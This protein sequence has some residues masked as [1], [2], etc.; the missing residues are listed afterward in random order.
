[1]SRAP[2]PGRRVRT[3]TI[4]QMEAVEC[5]AAALAIVLAHHDRFVPLEELRVACGVSRD[6]SKASNVLKAARKYGMVA[7]GFRKEPADLRA[8]N[9][10]M[11]V[12]WNFNHFLV[13]E[14]FRKDKV[15]LNDPASG[16][17]VVT[18]AEFDE[19]FT[20]VVLTFEPG[21]DFTTGGQR[22]GILP[23]LRQRLAGSEMAA[24]FAIITG[25][26]LV[27][28]GLVIP[29]FT[30]VFVDDVLIGGLRDWLMPLIV[31]MTL[32]AVLRALLTALQERSLLRL[33]TKLALATSS[34]FLWHVLRLPMEFYSQRFPG[35]IGSR[36]Q[37]NDRVA[38]LLSGQLASTAISLVTI[39]FYAGVMFAYDAVLTVIGV[40]FAV[41]NVLA[42]RYVSRRRVDESQKL[43]RAR[44]QVIGV[45]MGGLQMME[46]LKAT[47][48]ESDF[49]AQW[50]GRYAS[51]TN[52]EQALGVYSAYLMSVPPLLD[53]LNTAAI[54]AVGGLRVMEGHLSVG[55]LVAF[56]SL[57]ASFTGPVNQLVNL[58]GT[59][60]EVQGD[61]ARLDDVLRYEVDPL[62]ADAG[63]SETGA[64]VRLV[65][66]VELRNVTF[67]YSRLEPPLIKDFNLVVP[68][69]ARVALVGASGSGK[70]TIS[71]LISGLYEPWEG[72]VLF[73]G[74]PRRETSRAVLNNSVGFVDQDIFMFGGTVRDNL[75][76]W[77]TTVAETSVVLAGRDACIHDDIVVR[78]DGYDARVEEDGANF[79]GGQR[80]R[81]EIARALANNPTVL[82]LDEATS[83]LDATTEKAIDDH[84]RR[85]GCTCLIVAHRL[86]TIR[87]ADQI[88]VMER[89]V[90]VERGTH[91]ELKDAGG[92]YARLIAG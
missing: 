77:D 79:S 50:A 65:G 4:L 80:Q 67:G 19:A 58:G 81:M 89:G 13:V 37:I 91:E 14:G 40:A 92:P 71:K 44:G 49:F 42:L 63:G 45:S 69:G 5:G 61:M 10:P 84:L 73:D 62:V 3:P 24:V 52:A 54:L 57:M 83:A 26:F 82:V 22:P 41:V 90:V 21:P 39:V 18:T 74:T 55:M 8:V 29:V 34:R 88:L 35:E 27:I 46:D 16:P 9:L 75:T 30:R 64:V 86:S 47:G 31:G 87:D 60:Q 53:T 48:S 76:L 28:P 85:R 36:V 68:P 25:L 38:G 12:F 17:R 32:A 11:I 70:S 56:Q 1:T 15:Y 51:S 43:L 78:R 23:A 33:E 59:L 20:G 7:K 72:E 6:G 66:Q 2:A